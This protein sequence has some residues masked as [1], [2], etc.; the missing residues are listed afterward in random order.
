[1]EGYLA[2]S[3]NNRCFGLSGQPGVSGD[4]YYREERFFI[5]HSSLDYGTIL[6]GENLHMAMYTIGHRFL[7]W[8][9]TSMWRWRMEFAWLRWQQILSMQCK[10]LGNA[11]PH[12]KRYLH[13]NLQ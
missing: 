4:I 11:A 1:M 13:G 6:Q 10:N 9:P 8:F 2:V 5:T 7:L 3:G 12:K